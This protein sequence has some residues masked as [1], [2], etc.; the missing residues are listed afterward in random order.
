MN[1]KEWK[2]MRK[3]RLYRFLISYFASASFIALASG[4]TYGALAAN[5]LL[6]LSGTTGGYAVTGL[7]TSVLVPLLNVVHYQ[8]VIKTN[9]YQ[10][11]REDSEREKDFFAARCGRS[12][13]SDVELRIG[14]LFSTSLT[15]TTASCGSPLWRGAARK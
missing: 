6:G 11:F 1:G 15:P 7:T 9:T 12:S 5:R 2:L 4:A 8:V 13:R 3:P 10:L 14:S